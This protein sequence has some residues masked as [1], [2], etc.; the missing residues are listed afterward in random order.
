MESVYAYERF[1]LNYLKEVGDY[2]KLNKQ[3]SN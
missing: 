2:L 1:D 3:V